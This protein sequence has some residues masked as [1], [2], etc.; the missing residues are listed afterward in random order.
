MVSIR[1]SSLL[2][3]LSKAVCAVGDQQCGGAGDHPV[4]IIKEM[5]LQDTQENGL[6]Q[7]ST[8]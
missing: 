2:Y 7:V 3:S 8:G 1:A 5:L 4:I 6:V